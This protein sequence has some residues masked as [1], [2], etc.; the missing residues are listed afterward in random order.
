MRIGGRIA[1]QEF[2]IEIALEDRQLF[3]IGHHLV[4][5]NRK[6][7]ERQRGKEEIEGGQIG[8][9]SEAQR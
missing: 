1:E 5:V 3:G 2:F 7:Q 8:I 9:A 6:R 4:G